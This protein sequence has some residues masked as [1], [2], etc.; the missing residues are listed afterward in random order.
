MCTVVY[1]PKDNSVFFASLRDESPLRDNAIEPRIYNDNDVEYLAPKDALAGG[2]WVGVNEFNNVIILLNGGFE[3]HIKQSSYRKS[4]GLI[5]TELLQSELPVIEWNLMDMTNIE[6]FTLVVWSDNNLFQLVWDGQEKHKTLMD[7]TIPHIWS[8]STLYNPSIKTHRKQLFDNWIET[9]PT[10]SLLNILN[11]F[12]SFADKENGFI[13]NRS[14]TLST[15]SYSFI[16]IQNSEKVIFNYLD[17]QSNQNT[18]T[19]FNV[20]NAFTLLTNS[21]KSSD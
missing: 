8:S 3:N 17:F 16:E 5:V 6:P 19:V 15:L 2:T 21:I 18:N 7:A 1:I 10:F 4:R 13:M 9:N 12:K 14:E 11:F 20:H